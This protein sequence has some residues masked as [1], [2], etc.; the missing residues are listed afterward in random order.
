MVLSAFIV[1]GAIYVALYVA[2]LGEGVPRLGLPRWCRVV[3]W[4][5][6]IGEL[7][8][9]TVA[10]HMMLDSFA[11]PRS[12]DYGLWSAAATVSLVGAHVWLFVA[13]TL[14]VRWRRKAAIPKQDAI[15]WWIVAAIQGVVWGLVL[16]SM[17]ADA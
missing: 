17:T 16:L 14:L 9:P 2:T 3:G 6:L 13:G 10:C 15:Q 5:L 1:F 4:L 11:R 7:L 8:A 12:S